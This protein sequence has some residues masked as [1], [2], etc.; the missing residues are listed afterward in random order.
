MHNIPNLDFWYFSGDEE[1]NTTLTATAIS[2]QSATYP[3]LFRGEG[4][5]RITSNDHG[6]KVSENPL[7]QGHKPPNCIFIQGTT[8]RAFDGLRRIIAVAADTIDVVA[9]VSVLTPGGTE[10][11]RPA[12]QF[13]HPCWFYGFKVHLSAASATTENLVCSIDADKG[14]AWDVNIYTKDMNGVQDDIYI[15]S[16]PIPIAPRDIL[17][18]TWANTNDTLWGLEL[19][20][21]RA[22]R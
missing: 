20:T 6:F 8:G 16:K 12:V 19:A 7:N 2:D 14:A 21:F 10:T 15:P 18:F 22:A 13:N 5:V 9:P 3:G 11:A 1:M 4:V 17:Y